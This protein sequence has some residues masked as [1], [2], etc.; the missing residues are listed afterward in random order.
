MRIHWPTNYTLD[1][2][3]GWRRGGKIILETCYGKLVDVTGGKGKVDIVKY[4]D[5]IKT[6]IQYR[7][8]A[9]EYGPILNGKRILGEEIW[10]YYYGNFGLNEDHAQKI[11]FIDQLRQQALAQRDEVPEDQT[12][13]Y[14]QTLAMME[15][16]VGELVES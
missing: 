3:L 1:A 8:E 7:I 11:A 5:F 6:E 16:F 15:R 14:N 4:L 9:R 13:N 12:D 10:D 2:A